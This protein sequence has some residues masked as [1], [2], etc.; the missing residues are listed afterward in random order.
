MVGCAVT[1]QLLEEE[2]AARQHY[3][4]EL[5]QLRRERT[6][7]EN[8]VF[9]NPMRL[10]MRAQAGPRPIQ[11]Q[12]L[13]QQRVDNVEERCY[14]ETCG[15]AAL[16]EQEG[17][18]RQVDANTAMRDLAQRFAPNGSCAGKQRATS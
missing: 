9:L 10:T 11:H 17:R 16:R 8:R 15:P 1:W 5:A 2:K 7:A 12:H 14:H 4:G 3:H 18:Q 6:A 13:P